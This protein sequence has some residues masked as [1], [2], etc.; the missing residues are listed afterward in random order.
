MTSR[1]RRSAFVPLALAG[2]VALTGCGR[3]QTGHS[4]PLTATTADAAVGLSVSALIET[5][6]QPDHAANNVVT[7]RTRH[8]QPA[9][10]G[11][12]AIVSLGGEGNATRVG[13]SR[14]TES[15][16][17]SFRY[18]GDGRVKGWSNTGA[19]CDTLR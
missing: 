19:F 6:G 1:C 15:C 11:F 10:L 12:G 14:Q 18:D 7:Y 3:I 2:I 9:R 13:A 8:R 16:T 17:W 5:F 4:A